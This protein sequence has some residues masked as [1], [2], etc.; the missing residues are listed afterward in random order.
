MNER[1]FPHLVELELPPGGFRHQS[2][3]FGA[4]HH[5]RGIPIRRGRGRH[6]GEQFHVRFC[7]P[8]AATADAFRERFGGRR[9]TYSPSKPGR[10]PGP[11]SRY[12][13]S[14]S[15]RVGGGK[16]MTP[17]D[18]RRLHEYLLDV[19]KVS[20]ISGEMRA[21]VETEWPELAHKLSPK[22]VAMIRPKE[23]P[24][25]PGLLLGRPGRGYVQNAEP[26]PTICAFIA[27]AL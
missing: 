1:D 23:K 7:F 18:L 21:V 4:F 19:E 20:S 24:W 12:Q 14:H 17:A 8:D 26:Y 15:P 11:R 6:E 16:V 3:E 10:P 9:L 27:A 25:P 13:R 22:E 2:V 5:D